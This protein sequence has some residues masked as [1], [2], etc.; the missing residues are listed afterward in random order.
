MATCNDTGKMTFEAGGNISRGARVKMS[1][2][3]TVVAAGAGEQSI[4][5]AL[6]AVA[7]GGRVS[8]KLW[9]AP[10]TH[11]VLTDAAIAVNTEVYGAASGAVSTSA[12]GAKLG[13]MVEATTGAGEGEMRYLRPEA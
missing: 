6:D 12:S 3:D 13:I 10:G 9:N 4:G 1:G 5:V 2:T 7:S 8:V 11:V